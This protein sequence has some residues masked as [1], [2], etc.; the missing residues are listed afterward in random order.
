MTSSFNHLFRNNILPNITFLTRFI[1]KKISFINKDFS[2]TG[3]SK[4]SQSKTFIGKVSPIYQ[5]FVTH[6]DVSNGMS[7]VGIQLPF[8]LKFR[9]L[10]KRPILSFFA[11]HIVNYPT[12]I[13]LTYAW[14]F[15]FL[16]GVSLLIQIF[17]L[18]DQSQYRN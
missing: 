6:P 17:T 9:R 15:G 12:P 2:N 10:V 18:K 13:N 16:A 5:K 4:S 3:N 7:Y 8:S 11:N 14:S 1:Q